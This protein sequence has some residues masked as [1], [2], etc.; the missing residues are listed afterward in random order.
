MACVAISAFT[1]LRTGR[2]LGGAACATPDRGLHA[3]DRFLVWRAICA[4]GD[5]RHYPKGEMVAG[6]R[7]E[8]QG[9]VAVQVAP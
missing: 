3:V 8:A 7:G 1:G 9:V 2:V 4:L 6:L 5:E